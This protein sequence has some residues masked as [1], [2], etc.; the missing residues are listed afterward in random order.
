MHNVFLQ[1]YN[2]DMADGQPGVE[3]DED[4]DE[5][6]VN[7]IIT[8]IENSETKSAPPSVNSSSISLPALNKD[9]D[10]STPAL[11][12]K[13]LNQSPS[14]KGFSILPTSTGL[15]QRKRSRPDAKGPSDSPEVRP[16]M[17]HT[18]PEGRPKSEQII[19]SSNCG[20]GKEDD[21][22]PQ[23]PVMKKRSKSDVTALIKE[24]QVI[25]AS[26]LMDVILFTCYPISYVPYM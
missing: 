13:S 7:I 23:T 19:R 18:R 22:K 12:D 11:D 14:K 10:K 8:P 1:Q 6:F 2:S 25:T 26:L 24:R 16:K 15:F 17:E 21:S 5:D 9:K 4:V 20:S 3:H